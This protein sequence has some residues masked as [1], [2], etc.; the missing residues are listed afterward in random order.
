MDHGEARRPLFIDLC[1]QNPSPA[2]SF[3]ICLRIVR[4]QVVAV[5]GD[6][7]NDAPA[8]KKADVGFAMGITGAYHH[9]HRPRLLLLLLLLPSC[10]LSLL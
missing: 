8:L 6:G 7:T 4:F 5:T 10:S 3:T 2:L 1:S 9:H